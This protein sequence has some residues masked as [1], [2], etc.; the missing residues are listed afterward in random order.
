MDLPSSDPRQTDLISEDLRP[1][2]RADRVVSNRFFF[3]LSPLFFF[4]CRRLFKFG[5]ALTGFVYLECA[6][7]GSL[8]VVITV[9]CTVLCSASCY[10]TTLTSVSLRLWSSRRNRLT[11]RTCTH[12][13]CAGVKVRSVLV[14][15][16]NVISRHRPP[17]NF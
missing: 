2:A 7:L 15:E 5:L 4:F 12:T 13:Y 10:A 8:M 14:M 6:S 11:T 16:T 9:H 3:S 1:N 17:G